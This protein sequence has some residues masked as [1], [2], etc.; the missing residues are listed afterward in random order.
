MKTITFL[1]ALIFTM[2]AAAQNSWT[3]APNG[4][5]TGVPTVYGTITPGDCAG[6]FSVNPP[7][8]YDVGQACN[9][10]TPANLTINN[11]NAGAAPGAVF[12]GSTPLTISANTI[13]AQLASPPPSVTPE[14]ACA[15][16]ADQS[17]GA[18]AITAG[19]STTITGTSLPAAYVAPGQLFGITASA[20][21]TSGSFNAGPFKVLSAIPNLITVD[22]STPLGCTWSSGGSLYLWCSNQTTDALSTTLYSTSNNYSVP[23][24]TIAAKSTYELKMQIGVYSSSAPPSAYYKLFYDTTNIYTPQGLATWSGSSAGYVGEINY[25][26]VALS[27]SVLSVSEFMSG[28]FSSASLVAAENTYSPITVSSTTT[29]N[30]QPEIGFIATGVATATY[31][32]SLPLSGTGNVSLGTFNA[33]CTATATMAVTSGVAGAITITS[34]GQSCTAAPTTATCTSGTATCS[35]T[36]T[37]TSTLGGAPGNAVIVYSLKPTP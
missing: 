23:A 17:I 14:C 9:Q 31:V 18:N 1:F 36:V 6:W 32:S 37:L 22:P 13:G 30:L 29:K 19:T 16:A 27:P 25:N 33:A 26:I 15:M 4:T 28:N 8:L 12:N 24:N 7:L 20:T 21:C 5:L 34:R 35:G 2:T 10:G 11:S 3:V